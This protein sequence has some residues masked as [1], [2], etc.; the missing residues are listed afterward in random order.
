MTPGM[1]DLG[2]LLSAVIIILAKTNNHPS[3]SLRLPDFAHPQPHTHSREGGEVV[4][5]SSHK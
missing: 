2:V 4:V 5:L 3:P 1:E